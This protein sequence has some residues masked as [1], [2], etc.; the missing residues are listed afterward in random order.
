MTIERL[1][2]NLRGAHERLRASQDQLNRWEKMAIIGRLASGFAHD[3]NNPLTSLLG[4]LELSRRQA[5]A[6]ELEGKIPEYLERAHSGSAPGP[7]A[8]PAPRSRSRWRT[9]ST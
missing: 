9:G 2:A 1:F 7:S 3:L 6:E 5:E 8:V 4:F